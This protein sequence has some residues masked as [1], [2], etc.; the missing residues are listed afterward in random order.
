MKLI[1][2]SHSIKMLFFFAA[3]S[4]RA[5]NIRKQKEQ[6]LLRDCRAQ[7]RRGKIEN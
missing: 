2:F 1:L 5:A 7:K 4:N 6:H 3:F